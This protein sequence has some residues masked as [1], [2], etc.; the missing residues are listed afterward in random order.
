M[1]ALT[2]RTS[3]EIVIGDPHKPMGTIKVVKV[4][5]DKVRLSF[6]FPQEIKINRKELAEQKK[7]NSTSDI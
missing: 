4:N 2:R 7:Q 3:E 1:L 5:G 6:D